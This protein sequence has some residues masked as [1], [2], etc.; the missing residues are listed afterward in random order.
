MSDE[1]NPTAPAAAPEAPAAPPKPES[2]EGGAILSRLA[3]AERREREARQADKSKDRL[4]QVAMEDPDRFR[5]LMG[6]PSAQPQGKQRDTKD[7]LAS[8][9]DSLEQMLRNREERDREESLRSQLFDAETKVGQFVRDRQ[10]E[11]P[12]LTA[13]ELES[14]VFN[15]MRQ[16]QAEGQ[17]LS[18]VQAARELEQSLAAKL[19][20]LAQV[21]TLREKVLGASSTDTKEPRKVQQTL[22]NDMHGSAPRR[23]SGDD[24]LESIDEALAKMERDLLKAIR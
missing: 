9:V 7:E 5:L 10:E 15:R 6:G 21:K 24:D 20:R 12:L 4:L 3:E 16:A 14:A 13:L 8:K 19:D 18:E 23:D 22:S 11:F 2:G 17:T 1:S